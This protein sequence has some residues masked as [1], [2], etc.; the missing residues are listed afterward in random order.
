[1][2]GEPPCS[3]CSR[4]TGFGDEDR[5]EPPVNLGRCPASGGLECRAVAQAVAGLRA[6]VERLRGALRD[7][8]A[9]SADRAAFVALGPRGFARA[10]RIA[11][12]ALAATEPKP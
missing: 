9:M 2:S 3:V 1:M 6:D 7:V 11:R 4:P 8:L 5:G 12:D 10:E